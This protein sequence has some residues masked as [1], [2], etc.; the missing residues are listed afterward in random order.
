[1]SFFCHRR[2]VTSVVD[3]VFNVTVPSH[4]LLYITSH[5]SSCSSSQP[6]PRELHNWESSPEFYLCT[7]FDLQQPSSAESQGKLRYFSLHHCLGFIIFFFFFVFVIVLFFCC[8]CS[9]C[10]FSFDATAVWPITGSE[11]TNSYK[12][13]CECLDGELVSQQCVSVWPNVSCI[14]HVL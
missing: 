2:S 9:C 7:L 10:L 13:C 5:F 6:T 11:G 3:G 12:L 8:C 4:F 14:F 1:M